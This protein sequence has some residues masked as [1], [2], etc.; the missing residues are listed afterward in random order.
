[1]RIG[2]TRSRNYAA[3]FRNW[4]AILKSEG[5]HFR[6]RGS[7]FKIFKLRN[8]ISKLRKFTNRAEYISA[9]RSEDD[10][11]KQPHI[12]VLFRAVLEHL[13]AKQALSLTIVTCANHASKLFHISIGLFPPLLKGACAC[14]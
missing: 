14:M 4:V 7:N 1:M 13:D 9:V 8:A 6:N 11:S 5:M 12:P 10:D 3:L 2:V